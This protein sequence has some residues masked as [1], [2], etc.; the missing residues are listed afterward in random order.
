MSN[1][2]FN[3][4]ATVGI[5]GG[6]PAGLMTAMELGRK[7]VSC[8][9]FEQETGEPW[10]P[11]A[12]SSTTRTM[13]HYRRHGIAEEIRDVGIAEDHPQDVTYFTRYGTGYELARLK[14]QSRK[15]ARTWAGVKNDEWPTPEPV[16]RSNQLF[17]E[18]V[19]RRTALS[20]QSVE[21]R[22]GHRVIEVDP[23]PLG[24]RQ[25]PHGPPPVSYTHLTLPTKA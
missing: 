2:E 3:F 21:V 7:G 12:N 11:K 4:R 10:L 22:L 17:I 24:H 23:L 14:G 20:H 5:V 9:V 19:L 18:P 16:S 15:E 25:H 6:G 1:S 13:E 8:V